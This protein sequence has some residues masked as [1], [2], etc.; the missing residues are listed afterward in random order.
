MKKVFYGI[1]VFFIALILG[2]LFTPDAKIKESP[3]ILIMIGG[4]V[5]S[6]YELYEDLTK[7]E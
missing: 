2:S 6:V 1:A 7:Y 5:Y 3:F 4:L